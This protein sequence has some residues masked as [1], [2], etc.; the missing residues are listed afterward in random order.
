M[1]VLS[2]KQILSIQDSNA[3]INIWEGAVRS[4]KT[5]A[6]LWRFIRELT[7]GEKGAYAIICRTYRLF[8]ENVLEQLK[9]MLGYQDVRHLVGRG[10][11]NIFGKTIYVIGA[12]DERAEA[13]I[14]GPTFVGA[15][16]DEASII[17]HSV[18]KQLVARCAIGNAKIFA[19]TNPDSPYHWLYTDYLND[20][21]DVKS[22]KFQ[23]DDNPKLT[24]IEKDYFNRQYRGL[25]HK[26]FILGLWVQAE[27]AVYGSFN[28]E[29]HVIDYSPHAAH[30]WILGI[31]Y[32]TSNPCA[33]VL[34]G[35]SSMGVGRY[36]VE[37]VYYYDSKIHQRQK[38]DTE[39]A[40]DLSAFLKDVPVS[41]IY[42]DPSA[43]SF[44]LELQKQG[45]QN[46]YEAKNDVKNGICQVDMY[47]NNGTLKICRQCTS[48]IKEFQS[49]VWNPKK[50]KIGLDE[51]LK[52]NDHALDALRYALYSHFFGKDENR[53]TAQ[54]L[55]R[56]YLQ[57]RDGN[58]NLPHFFR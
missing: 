57:T 49:Y 23:L 24:T 34:I 26:R 5:Y 37:R 11:L 14:R 46:I 9:N 42:I 28:D 19:T 47:L 54:D 44:K 13:K 27:G 36:W 1:N 53:L 43:L 48:L 51:P 22:W 50:Q 40:E 52:E 21:V 16:V 12:D 25:W 32:G 10:Q 55:D 33:F 29:E 30:T 2:A 18:F 17:P 6:S 38:T 45:F 4:G 8:Q 58:N 41:A 3:K 39:Y 35:I 31:D 7:E 56:L 15:Y 20:N